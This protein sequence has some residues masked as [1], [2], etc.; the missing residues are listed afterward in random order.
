MILFSIIIPIHAENGGGVKA[1]GSEL[2]VGW[3]I[4]KG[5]P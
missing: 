2:F 5:L 1:A 4:G 3:A